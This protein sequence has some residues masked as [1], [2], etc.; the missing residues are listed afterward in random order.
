MRTIEW[1]S[2][3]FYHGSKDA[4]FLSLNGS[5]YDFLRSDEGAELLERTLLYHMLLVGPLPSI[6]FAATLP[7]SFNTLFKVEPISSEKHPVGMRLEAVLEFIRSTFLVLMWHL[8]AISQF[9]LKSTLLTLF[10]PLVELPCFT[11]L[12][13]RL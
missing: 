7:G 2:N 11:G 13:G 1:I 4:S 9:P 3:V 6:N 5:L 12:I 8:I 10:A